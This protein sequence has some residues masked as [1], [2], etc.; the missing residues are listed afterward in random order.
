M[1]CLQNQALNRR[2]ILN[3]GGVRH[4][5]LW[6]TLERLPH[7]RL[8]RLRECNSH[9]VR[10]SSKSRILTTHIT[11]FYQT[12]HYKKSLI[13]VYGKLPSL[14]HLNLAS[15]KECLMYWT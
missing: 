9:E 5:V 12:I 1:R 7:T 3:V 14:R 11:T 6:R 13:H 15:T 4:E 2:V 10:S 8:G